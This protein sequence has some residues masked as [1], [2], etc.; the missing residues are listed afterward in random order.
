MYDSGGTI[1]RA[2]C[3]LTDNNFKCKAKQDTFDIYEVY[4]WYLSTGLALRFNMLSGNIW[5]NFSLL[6]DD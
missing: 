4:L 3:Q 1:Q 6:N 5:L 2:G